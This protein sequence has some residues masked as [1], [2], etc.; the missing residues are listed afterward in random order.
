MEFI[1]GTDLTKNSVVL[2]NTQKILK[3]FEHTH[4]LFGRKSKDAAPEQ[5]AIR[6]AE[7]NLKRKISEVS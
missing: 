4:P 7:L 3:Y 5:R 6:N 2:N 1:C